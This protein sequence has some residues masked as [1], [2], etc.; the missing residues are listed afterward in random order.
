M[1]ACYLLTGTS[2]LSLL[3]TGIQGYFQFDIFGL[4]HLQF[5]LLTS[6]VYLFTETLI[7]FFFVGTGVSVKE[8]TQMHCL[9]SDYHYRS[10]AIKRVIYP[11]TLLNIILVMVL[12][13][14][15]GGV[16]T[17]VIS[18]WVHALLFFIAWLHFGWTIVIQHR[19]F[20]DNT[21]IFYDLA[22]LDLESEI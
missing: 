14:I 21:Q 7:I 5:A 6:V 16:H 15:G 22:K 19:C 11:P 9:P 2:F 13:I 3:V 20:R 18:T 17:E 12:F 4:P 8:F 1:Y 10:I